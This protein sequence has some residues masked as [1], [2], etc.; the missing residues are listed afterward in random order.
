[1]G[2]SFFGVVGGWL[3]APSDVSSEAVF[4][5]AMPSN[6]SSEGDLGGAIPP[7]VSSAFVPRAFLKISRN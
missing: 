7:I 1:M 3:A 4:G 2:L 6:V 5:V